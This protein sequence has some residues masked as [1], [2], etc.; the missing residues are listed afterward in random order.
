[1]PKKKGE[2]A[3]LVLPT[4]IFQS[5]EGNCPQLFL[6]RR[7]ICDVQTA[8]S[9]GA[10]ELMSVWI[11][12]GVCVAQS[13]VFGEL[14]IFCRPLNI[15]LFVTSICYTCIFISYIVIEVIY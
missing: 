3:K 12:S 2:G 10:S 15:C 11:F 8:D 6:S 13:S 5:G 4:S 14:I 7:C 9:Y 1:M